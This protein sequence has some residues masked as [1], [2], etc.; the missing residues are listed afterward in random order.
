MHSESY[1]SKD[2]TDARVIA[3]TNKDLKEEIKK[4]KFREDLFHRLAVIIINVPPL[5]KRRSRY[6]CDMGLVLRQ[7]FLTVRRTI[8]IF[9]KS[10]GI[11][12]GF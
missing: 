5:N 7:E 8:K 12:E 1:G 2:T 3:A 4:G 10:Q 9:K 6:L 11:S